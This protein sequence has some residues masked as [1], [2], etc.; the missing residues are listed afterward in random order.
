MIGMDHKVNNPNGNF[1]VGSADQ[2]LDQVDYSKPLGC[3]MGV[4]SEYHFNAR[5]G[6]FLSFVHSI[7]Q[8]AQGLGGIP[9]YMS[10]RF[11]PQTDAYLGMERFPLTVAIELSCLT[12]W[13]TADTYLMT[14]QSMA[15][16]AGG[17]PHWGLKLYEPIGTPGLYRSALDAYHLAVATIEDGHPTTFSS[18]FSTTEGLDPPPL[19]EART[20]AGQQVSVLALMAAA[21]GLVPSAPPVATV[22]AA[23]RRYAPSLRMNPDHEPLP[24]GLAARSD[25][26]LSVRDLARRLI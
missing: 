12:P 16:A 1:K 5:A 21:Q 15:I 4:G 6:G 20:A 17:F 8:F 23:A 13:P 24:L 25:H 14:A 3:Y 22:R 10:L 19:S 2:V 18:P 11:V 26:A 9:G 7:S